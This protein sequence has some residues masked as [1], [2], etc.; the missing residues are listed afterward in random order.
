MTSK[1]FNL[2]RD[3]DWQFFLD[4]L[5]PYRD[6]QTRLTVKVS[7]Y[8][9]RRSND[10]NAFY[11]TCVVTPLS[12]FTGFTVPEMHDEILGAYTGWETRTIHGHTREYPRRRSTF[13]ETMETVDFMGLIQTGQAIAADLGVI[14]PDQEKAA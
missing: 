5:L 3:Q 8:K 12:E 9:K 13:P 4:W 10:I 6:K 1:T 11:W 7:N 2:C 14:L